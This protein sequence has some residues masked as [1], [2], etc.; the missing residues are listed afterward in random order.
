[1]AGLHGPL[2]GEKFRARWYHRQM[3]AVAAI[4]RL[5]KHTRW[6]ALL[7]VVAASGC[8][9]AKSPPAD[10]TKTSNASEAADAAE[11]SEAAQSPQSVE[12]QFA[13]ES[14]PIA[15]Q[16]V[17]IDGAFTAYVEAKSPPKLK[18]EG[19][20][21]TVSI[22]LGWDAEVQCYVYAQ[23]IDAGGASHALLE[24]AAKSV[25][26][27]SVGP[28]FLDH[29]ALD[30]MLGLRGVYH[31][32]RDDGTL[33]AGDFKLMTMPRS[34]HPVLCTHDGPGYAKSFQRVS[35]EFAKS[36][37]FK[38]EQPTPQRGELWT[39]SLD[40]TPAGVSRDTTYALE[41]GKM[42]RLS[43]SSRFLSS[44]PGEMAFQD[45]ADIVTC[46][47][48]GAL[49]SGKYL[50]LDDGQLK[51]EMDVSRTKT[52][53]DYVGTIEGKKVA[54]S[55]KS[56]KPVMTRYAIELKFKALARAGK[57]AKFEQWEYTPSVEPTAAS[58]VSYDMTPAD[59]GFSIVSAL[60]ERS[61]T[62]KANA[63]GVLRQ[64]LVDL[65]S[66]KL[67]IDLVE[68]AGEL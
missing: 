67:Q 24:A 20:V 68:E 12:A 26:F 58:K 29:H 59:D 63:R 4:R 54:G 22:D 11:G 45:K 16:V 33:L 18:Q 66:R 55:F 43:L 1:M 15:K 65:G 62:L 19:Q 17:K 32:E 52:G 57:P 35:T 9:G 40:G 5:R 10:A 23:P 46:D 49:I 6:T 7:S 21:I 38:S 28:Y 3:Y 36:F 64:G 56:K 25:K 14:E 60:A 2:G 13:R 34:E 53:Y 44:A 61:I 41:D 42:R 39:M 50:S 51:L 8:G 48:E 47:K 37:Q 27:K 30:P 31:V